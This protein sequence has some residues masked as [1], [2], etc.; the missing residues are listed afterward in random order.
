MQMQNPW[1]E[2]KKDNEEYILPEDKPI[3]NE[4][5]RII[6]NDE[7]KI[8][9]DIYPFPYVGNV[10]E[11]PIVLLMLNPGFDEK[12]IEFYNKF[13]ETFQNQLLHK[14]D[15]ME[16]PYYPL[17]PI[18]K[19]DDSDYWPKRFRQITEH[20]HTHKLSRYICNIQFFSYSSKKMNWDYYKKILKGK[21]LLSQEYNFFLVKQAIKRDA[22]IIF[23][24]RGGQSRWHNAIEELKTYEN[25]YVAKAPFGAYLTEGNFSK[26]L[27][28]RIVNIIN[29]KP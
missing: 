12:E 3:I 25:Q 28:N 19:K 18:I 14:Y 1:A 20:T 15:L 4:F 11:A 13:K 22:I 8:H 6:N 2:F 9:T 7:L 10:L 21:F 16:Y 23:L 24:R 26:E 5:N 29:S 17:N 27:I